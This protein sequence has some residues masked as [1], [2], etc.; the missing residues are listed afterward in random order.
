MALSFVAAGAASTTNGTAPAPGLPAG[1]AAGD[2]LVCVFHSRNVTTGTAALSAGWTQRVHDVSAGGLLAVWS[3]VYEAGDA[4]PTV[5]LT[6]HATGNSGDS[7]IAR[8]VAF[9][10]AAGQNASVSVVGTV[11][12]NTAAVN[13]GPI[14]GLTSPAGGAVLVV[15]GKLDDF[16]SVATLSGDSLTWAED[17]DTPNTLGSDNGLVVDHALTASSTAVTAKTFTVTGGTSVAGKGVMLAL[18]ETAPAAALVAALAGAGTLA[19]ALTTAIPL[20]SA[21][22]GAGSVAAGLTTA[23]A[24]AAGL[25]G[26]GALAADLT[27]AAPPAA[28]FEAALSG[29][30]SL[31]AGLTTAILLAAQMAGAGTLSAPL[32]TQVRLASALSGGASA[33]AALTTQIR[34]ASQLAGAGSL[35]AAL[36]TQIPLAAALSA[37]GSLAA[38]L[39]T[40]VRMSGQLSGAGSLAAHLTAGYYRRPLTGLGAQEDFAG[41]ASWADVEAAVPGTFSFASHDGAVSVA[42]DPVTGDRGFGV[43]SGGAAAGLFVDDEFAPSDALAARVRVR[44]PTTGGTLVVPLTLYDATFGGLSVQLQPSTGVV[45]VGGI[46]LAPLSEADRAGALD[47]VLRVAHAGGMTA[48]RAA[49]VDGSGAVLREGEDTYDDPGWLPLQTWE[50][51]ASADADGTAA[52][53]YAVEVVPLA[54]DPDPFWNS[55]TLFDAALSGGGTLAAELTDLAPATPLSATLAGAGSLSATLTTP[56]APASLAA[57]LGGG[58][59]LVAVLT[60]PPPPA[61]PPGLDVVVRERVAA[62]TARERRVILS[63]VQRVAQLSVTVEGEGGM[64]PGNTTRVRTKF[65]TWD[66]TPEAPTYGDP[67]G[68]T[69][70]VTDAA[71][72]ELAHVII[73]SVGSVAP[74]PVVSSTQH[75]TVGEYVAGIVLPETTPYVRFAWRGVLEGEPIVRDG[76]LRIARAPVVVG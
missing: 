57:T 9:R 67:D 49:V 51:S 2:L 21:L 59:D 27:N 1:V 8:I 53:L 31:A 61:P 41:Y 40:A 65:P 30:G 11:S 46:V 22:A 18:A 3:R 52:A 54:V 38:G 73:P 70:T 29:A 28:Q 63:A 55:L 6:N 23:V 76:V 16:T 69:L 39:T 50:A 24:L 68:L 12:T 33:A 14:T 35:S 60:V 62:V 20:A 26:S 34:L 25:S 58:G 42:T 32:T 15:G 45:S 7:A 56:G 75:V 10:P 17:S 47:I 43:A 72:A 5:T 37:S 4:A 36:A 74:G 44:V 71:G 19:A 48:V 66:F 13:I 64:I